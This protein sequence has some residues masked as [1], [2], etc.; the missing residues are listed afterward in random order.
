[1]GDLI[2]V[3]AKVSDEWI[4]GKKGDKEGMFPESFVDRIPDN[5]P[6]KSDKDPELVPVPAS[7]PKSQV[8][9]CFF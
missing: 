8:R 9:K 1:M 3:T 5:L 6:L 4:Y 2:E 7:P